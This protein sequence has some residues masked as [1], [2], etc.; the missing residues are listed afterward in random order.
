MLL[1]SGLLGL[2]ICLSTSAHAFELGD[3]KRIML[4]ALSEIQACSPGT[5][6]VGDATTL[7]LA[8][9]EEDVNVLRKDLL[10]SHFYNPNKPLNMLRYGS[11]ERVGVLSYL[12]NTFASNKTRH[13]FGHLTMIAQAIHH[14]QDMGA[15]PHVVPVNH[16]PWDSFE[17]FEFSGDISSGFTC[18]Q[19]QDPMSGDL[20][21]ILKETALE[22]L[23]RVKD[24][25]VKITSGT[26]GSD[27]LTKDSVSGAAFWKDSGNNDFGSYGILG[28]NFGKVQFIKDEIS[29]TV[30]LEFYVSFKR[31]QLKLA[32]RSTLK[33]L[34]WFLRLTAPLNLQSP[35]V[36]QRSTPVTQK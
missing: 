10:F 6:D 26:V 22:T 5:F 20:L 24:A 23:A 27:N 19:L 33:A 17:N 36:G 7:W 18:E 2:L 32:V 21:T 28:N 29:Y 4:Q 9:L 35:V 12:L 8:D 16:G 25:R 30:P 14:I 15:P 3:H 11:G 31:E 34:N 13:R 1:R